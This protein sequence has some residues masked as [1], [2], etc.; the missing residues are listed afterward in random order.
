MWAV[1]FSLNKFMIYYNVLLQQFSIG[2]AGF[3]CSGLYVMI[4]SLKATNILYFQNCKQAQYYKMK[5]ESQSQILEWCS[6]KQ[7]YCAQIHKNENLLC[8]GV[9]KFQFPFPLP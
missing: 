6:I 4:F 7:Y 9:R 2:L 3:V 1:H 8:R 5:L